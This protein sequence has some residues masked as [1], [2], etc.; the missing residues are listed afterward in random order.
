MTGGTDSVGLA[1]GEAKQQTGCT[2]PA[3]S[4]S[5][6]WGAARAVAEANRAVKQNG[7]GA[8]RAALAKRPLTNISGGA[9]AA[10]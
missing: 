1:T 9:T 6:S 10:E 4:V 5:Q 7:L 2:T 3:Q 8:S